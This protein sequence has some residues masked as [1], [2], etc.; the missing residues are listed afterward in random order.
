MSLIVY[1][2]KSEIKQLL[3]TKNDVYF[4]VNTQLTDSD[5]EKVVLKTIDGARYNSQATFIGRT[6]ALGALSKSL[7]S[8]GSK[9]LLNIISHPD[10]CFDVCECGNNALSI[11]P[12]IKDGCIYWKTIKLPYRGTPDCD[13]LYHGKRYTDFYEFL[14]DAGE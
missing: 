4:Q 3:V 5:L 11:L 1:D 13:V 7:L 9:T 14:E 2:D 10:V 12:L 6:E 8:T